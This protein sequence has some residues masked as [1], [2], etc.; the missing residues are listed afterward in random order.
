MSN[1][2]APH[3]LPSYQ[4]FNINFASTSVTINLKKEVDCNGKS[5]RKRT[6]SQ[7]AVRR[8]LSGEPPKS[9]YKSLDKSKPWFFKWLKRYRKTN[10][11]WFCDQPKTPHLIANKTAEDIE[12]LVISTRK[13]L[14]EIKY[15]QVG[16]VCFQWEIKKLDTEPPPVWT[17]NRIVEEKWPY[18]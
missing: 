13:R 16:A 8:Y 10:P 1:F 18:L 7:Q 4:F 6:S 14:E 12:N 3:R 15:S 2:V 11:D 9:I 17:V 5:Q